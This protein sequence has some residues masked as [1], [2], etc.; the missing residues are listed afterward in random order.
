[1]RLIHCNY[2]IKTRSTSQQAPH[3]QP[4]YYTPCSVGEE[5]AGSVRY[6]LENHKVALRGRALTQKTKELEEKQAQ[7]TGLGNI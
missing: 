4:Y 5:E 7:E 3:Y 1:M 2:F 6:D